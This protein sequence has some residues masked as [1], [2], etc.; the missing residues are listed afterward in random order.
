MPSATGRG[1]N[2]STNRYWGYVASALS[3]EAGWPM[4]VSV[5]SKRGQRWTRLPGRST[6]L[7]GGLLERARSTTLALLGVTAAVGLAIVALALNQSLPLIPGSPIPGTSSRHA[8]VGKATVAAGTAV[9]KPRSTPAGAADRQ[10]QGASSTGG[11]HRAGA[12][13]EAPP[14]SAPADSAEF[15]VS[16]SAPAKPRG[17]RS[18]GTPDQQNPVPAAKQPQPASATPA[19]PTPDK[20]ESS[21]PAVTETPPPTA[22]TSEAPADESHVPPWSHGNGHAYGRGDD[23]G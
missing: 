17:G 21:P 16:P 4:G 3:I 7:G 12:P 5:H 10:G 9:E 13:D 20:P 14:G 19:V 23:G 6:L 18:H 15:V 11:P 22:T 2:E 1:L 8:A